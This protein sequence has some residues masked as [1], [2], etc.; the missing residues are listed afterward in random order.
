MSLG[1]LERDEVI[2]HNLEAE[3]LLTSGGSD[4]TGYRNSL[5]DVYRVFD[6]I[7]QALKRIVGAME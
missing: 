4:G 3:K 7:L 5:G 1:K 2:K 6:N